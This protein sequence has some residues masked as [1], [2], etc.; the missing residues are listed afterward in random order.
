MDHNGTWPSA[1]DGNAAQDGGVQR[2]VFLPVMRQLLEQA[3]RG[4]RRFAAKLESAEGGN[5]ND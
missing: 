1:D 2:V 3:A 5:L 4:Q